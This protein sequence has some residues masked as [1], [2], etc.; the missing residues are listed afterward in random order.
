MAALRRTSTSASTRMCVAVW[1]YPPGTSSRTDASAGPGVPAGQPS[2]EPDQASWTSRDLFSPWRWKGF[3]PP[4]GAPPRV[5]R[6]S[7]AFRG[8]RF[9][10]S[11]NAVTVRSASGRHCASRETVMFSPDRTTKSTVSSEAPSGPRGRSGACRF[12]RS[13]WCANAASANRS[14]SRCQSAG[15]VLFWCPKYATPSAS[16]GLGWWPGTTRRTNTYRSEP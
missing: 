2:G 8:E 10:A 9:S 6:M 7:T 16:R 1:P 15:W 4:A 3:I 5:S 14:R 12:H 13:S 11:V